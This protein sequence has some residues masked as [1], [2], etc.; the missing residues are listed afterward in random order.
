MSLRDSFDREQ[1]GCRLLA[2]CRIVEPGGSDFWC[3]ACGSGPLSYV[4][5][6]HIWVRP[7]ACRVH[8]CRRLRM[9]FALRD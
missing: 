8:K 1:E 6:T 7:G 3:F 2:W 4:P 5:G 9:W